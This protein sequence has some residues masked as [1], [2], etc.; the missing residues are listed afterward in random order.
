MEHAKQVTAQFNTRSTVKKEVIGWIK[1]CILL[2]AAYVILTSSV[3][4]TRVSG[5]SMDPTLK[6]GSLVLINK[7]STFFGSPAHG[8]V[9]NVKEDGKSY[10]IIKRVVGLPGDRVA[11]QDGVVY[12]NGL[13]QIEIQTFGKSKDMAEV[14]VEPGRLFI[15]GDNRTPGQS[16]DS[17]DPKMGTISLSEVK[18]YAVISLFPFYRIMNPIQL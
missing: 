17:R 7:L 5:H 6:D 11:I 16:L 2:I 12:V 14:T 15:M 1:F 4:L 10:F 9:V 18:G 13:P 3:G 8:D